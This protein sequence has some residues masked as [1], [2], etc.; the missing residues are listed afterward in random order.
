MIG[1]RGSLS[2]RNPVVRKNLDWP[3]PLSP[4]K[5]YSRIRNSSRLLLSGRASGTVS[6]QSQSAIMNNLGRARAWKNPRGA[7]PLTYRRVRS[8]T[9]SKLKRSN[10]QN[11]PNDF[12]ERFFGGCGS[13]SR[14]HKSQLM[15]LAWG[16]GFGRC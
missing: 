6:Q 8:L 9:H 13:K 2:P 5:L 7:A 12:I 4:L 15:R 14:T 3:K 11:A 16:P 1:F 10:H